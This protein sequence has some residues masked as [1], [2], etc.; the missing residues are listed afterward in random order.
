MKTIKKALYKLLCSRA[1]GAIIVFFFKERIPDIR[2][3][4]FCFT[5]KGANMPTGIIAS[6][7]WGFYESAEIRFAEK[8]IKG[9]MDV[10]EMGGSCGV[11]TSHLVSKLLPGKKLIA[12]EANADLAEVWKENTGRKNYN[13][14]ELVL[15]NNVIHYGSDSVSFHISNNTTESRKVKEVRGDIYIVK[16]PAI[17]LKEIC[18]RFKLIEYTLVCDIEGAEVEIIINEDAALS[19]CRALLIE[20]HSTVYNGMSYTNE[21]LEELILSKGF[22]LRDQHGPV[23]Y[24]ERLPSRNMDKKLLIK[25]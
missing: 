14:A 25:H 20:M 6:V 24:F 17:T 10:I 8:Y 12:V 16:V 11:V 23:Y 5:F 13:K 9:N 22:A 18:R 15:L 1:I 4:G 19:T 2:W 3:K 7:F 21:M